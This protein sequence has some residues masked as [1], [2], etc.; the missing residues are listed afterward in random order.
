MTSPWVWYFKGRRSLSK[1]EEII[2][3]KLINSSHCLPPHS[4]KCSFQYLLHVMWGHNKYTYTWIESRMSGRY[5]C[6]AI[7]SLF[8]LHW[9]YET[10]L[11]SFRCSMLVFIFL[12][13]VQISATLYFYVK[14]LL[15]SPGFWELNSTIWGL[16]VNCYLL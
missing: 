12:S 14:F 10:I 7:I 8:Y 9:Y 15:E 6:C 1:N 2:N 5:H 3:R 16:G 4:P 13:V 11:H